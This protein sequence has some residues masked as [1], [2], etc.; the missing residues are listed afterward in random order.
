MAAKKRKLDRSLPFG[1]VFGAGGARYEQHGIQ[2]D[3]EELELPGFEDV[4]IP[5]AAIRTVFVEGDTSAF[6]KEIE[7]LQALNVELTGNLE[8]VEADKEEIQGKFDTLS[9]EAERLRSRV[10]E[11]E[12]LVTDPQAPGVAPVGAQLQLQTEEAKGKNK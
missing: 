8:A 7:R 9:I 2:F 1:E 4:K 5:E 11:L 6:K 10:T 3:G 12:G